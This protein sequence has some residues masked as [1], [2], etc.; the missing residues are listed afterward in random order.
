MEFTHNINFKIL[1]EIIIEPFG[2]YP[3]E[4]NSKILSLQSPSY[5]QFNINPKIEKLFQ[6]L[7]FHNVTRCQAKL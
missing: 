5:V 1:R 7:T 3:P 6:K 2:G 4:P